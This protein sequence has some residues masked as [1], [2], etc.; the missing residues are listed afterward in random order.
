MEPSMGD[1]FQASP[2]RAIL[3]PQDGELWG[4]IIDKWHYSSAIIKKEDHIE[5][6]NIK[7]R[8]Q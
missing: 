5:I 8:V 1:C 2:D 7:G 4:K 6:I 3:M